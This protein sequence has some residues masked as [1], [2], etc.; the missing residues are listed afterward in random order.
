MMS[1][2]IQNGPFVEAIV[3]FQQMRAEDL[4]IVPEIWRNLLDA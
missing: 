1:G 2:F 4:N 3:L